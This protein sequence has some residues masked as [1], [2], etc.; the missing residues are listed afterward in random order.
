MLDAEMDQEAGAALVRYN[1]KS[2]AFPWVFG[3]LGCWVLGIVFFGI[4]GV[5]FVLD[6]VLCFGW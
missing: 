5:V 4:W 6:F 3:C 1:L 2:A